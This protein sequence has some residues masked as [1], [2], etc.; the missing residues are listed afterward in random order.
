[1]IV[2]SPLILGIIFVIVGDL[3]IAIVEPFV[4]DKETLGLVSWAWPL[5]FYTI[6]KTI[7]PKLYFFVISSNKEVNKGRKQIKNE[8]NFPI[9]SQD[10]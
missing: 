2:Y 5:M 7:Y 8:K 9:Q 4:V 1:M 10:K 3:Q 6:M